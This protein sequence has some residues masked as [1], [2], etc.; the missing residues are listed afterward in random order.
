MPTCSRGADFEIGSYI[1]G[2]FQ[3]YCNKRFYQPV[4]LGKFALSVKKLSFCD[5]QHP[6]YFDLPSYLHAM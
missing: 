1:T 4:K 3:V 6:L 2:R 5:S